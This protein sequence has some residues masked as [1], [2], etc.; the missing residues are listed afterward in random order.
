M[1]MVEFFEA[2]ARVL[3]YIIKKVAEEANLLPAPGIYDEDRVWTLEER[4]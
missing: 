4:S 3:F 2:L 1:Q